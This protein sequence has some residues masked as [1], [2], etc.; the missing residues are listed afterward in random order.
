MDLLHDSFL[1]LD[2]YAYN[3]T[4]DAYDSDTLNYYTGSV[5]TRADNQCY[6]EVTDKDYISAVELIGSDDEGATWVTMSMTQ[7][8]PFDPLDPD[9]GGEYYATF[10]PADF[11]MSEWEPGTEIW[12]YVLCTDQLSNEEYFPTTANPADPDREGGSADYFTFAILPMYPPE[13][14]GVKILLVDGYGRRNYNYAQCFAAD[15]NIEPLEDIY[16]TTLRDAGYCYDKFDILGGGSS[17]HIHYLCTWNTDYDAVVW[18]TGPYFDGNL[19]D[20]EAQTEMRNYLAGG[21]K[22][23]LCGDR[24][25]ISAAP[26]SE[27]GNGEDSLGGEFLSGIMGCDYLSEVASAFSKPYLYAAGVPSVTVF[28]TPTALSLDT[29]LV[30]R[31]CPYLKDMSWVKTE[32]APPAGYVAQPL[33]TVLNPDVPQADMAIYVE[34]QGVGQSVLV[35]FDQSGSINHKKQYCSGAVPAGRQPYTPGNYEGRVDL[36]RTVLE[37][38][39]GLPSNGTGTGGTSDVPNQQV[40]KWAL[41]QNAPNPVAAGTEVRYEVARTSDVSIKVYNAMG[42]LVR[43]LLNEQVEP[44]RYAATWDAKNVQGEKVAAGVYFYKMSTGQ[45]SATKKMLVVR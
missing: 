11:G 8:Q 18:F 31:E 39:F 10:V 16:E 20:V 9:L 4:F 37:D 34:Y 36:F 42:Q 24:T 17:L 35:N 32:V 28:G 43:T 22:V 23:L 7:Y 21:G 12:Y 30:Y 29:M 38:V 45:Y 33:M 13:Y 26:E 15:D 14:D 41:H 19:F 2:L 25:A 40:F 6:V 44:G 3:S 1:E 27:G 5:P